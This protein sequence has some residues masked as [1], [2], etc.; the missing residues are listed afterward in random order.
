MGEQPFDVGGDGDQ[1]RQWAAVRLAPDRGG[2]LQAI[3]LGKV[4][5]QQGHVVGIA[6]QGF[7]GLLPVHGDVDLVA[8]L[9]QQ[10]LQQVLGDGAV[11]R[12]QHAAPRSPDGIEDRFLLS[13]LVRRRCPLNLGFQRARLQAARHGS[14]H[15]RFA[16]KLLPCPEK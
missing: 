15:R 14:G 8:A 2:D 12:Q 6:A 3:H 9:V 1:S 10:Q 11:F 16:L 7:Q 13:R 5:V 4:E